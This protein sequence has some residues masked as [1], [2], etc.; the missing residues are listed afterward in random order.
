MPLFAVKR[1][2][3]GVDRAVLDAAAFRA[4]SCTYD[5]DDLDWIR[6]YWEPGSD[7]VLCI[8]VARDADQVR[9][10]AE[11]SRI[12][13]DEVRQVDEVLPADYAPPAATA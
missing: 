1:I 10:H 5:Y 4:L 2:I 13:C 7:E 12:P 3:P 11:R 8:Y 9:E 6:S